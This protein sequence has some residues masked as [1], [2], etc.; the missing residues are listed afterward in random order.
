M[1]CSRSEVS[2]EQER[3]TSVSPRGLD[4]TI[5]PRLLKRFAPLAVDG[6]APRESDLVASLGQ[7]LFFDERLSKDRKLACASCHDVAHGGAD[8]RM[9][10]RLPQDDLHQRRS[11]PTVLN[12]AGAFAQSWDGR[13]GSVEDQALHP[14]LDAQAMGMK[15]G[16]AVVSRLKEI[17]GYEVLFKEAFPDEPHPVRPENIGRALGAYER[18]LVTPGRW[19]RFL[20]GEKTALTPHEKE[21]LRTFLN[22]GCMVCH[23]GPL[24][25]GTMF[26]RAGVVEPWP[27]QADPGRMAVT[28]SEQDRMMFK[29][30]TLRNVARTAPYFHDA[31]GADLP[32]AVRKMAKHQLG[33]ELSGREV[34]AIT[35]WLKAL[36]GDLP[37]ALAMKPALP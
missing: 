13:D 4:G 20:A 12:A 14:L 37:A 30:P 5:P 26:E 23:T 9:P 22:V 25:G 29:V 19:D 28:K 10:S 18:K 2:L 32:A 6:F 1:S 36:D 35:A 24:V 15:S 16:A 7:K 17:A 21:G 8:D 34:D 31:S 33:I 11:A 27:N 3:Y